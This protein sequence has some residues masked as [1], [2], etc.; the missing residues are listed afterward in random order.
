MYRGGGRDV[1]NFRSGRSYGRD[2]G[3]RDGGGRHVGG[4]DG[5]DQCCCDQC[6][7]AAMQNVMPIPSSYPLLS[8]VNK[9]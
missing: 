5:C 3:V 2:G 4:P 8:V 9:S 6:N 7:A 1:C